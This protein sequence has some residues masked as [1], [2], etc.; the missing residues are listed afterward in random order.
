MLE[1]NL[2]YLEIVPNHDKSRLEVHTRGS[3]Q[4]WKVIEDMVQKS[5]AR[6]IGG[7]H[8]MQYCRGA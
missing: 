4:T 7:E 1:T 6:G 3:S 2:G 8:A 5:G